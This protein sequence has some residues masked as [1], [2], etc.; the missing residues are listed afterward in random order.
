MTKQEF[1]KAAYGEHWEA[2][3]SNINDDGWVKVREYEPKDDAFFYLSFGY[4]RSHVDLVFTSILARWR[5]K[6]LRGVEKNNGWIKVEDIDAFTSD[7]MCFVVM[8]GKVDV[9]RLKFPFDTSQV[10]ADFKKDGITHCQF[11]APPPPPIY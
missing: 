3:K 11:I 9:I 1:I 10:L 6:K 2:L 8:R 7:G 5:L 4:D